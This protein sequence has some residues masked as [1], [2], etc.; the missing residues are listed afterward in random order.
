MKDYIKD[1]L[2]VL[3]VGEVKDVEVFIE[4]PI[5]SYV[6]ERRW[7]ESQQITRVERGIHFK[8]RVRV[9]DE[10]ARW[11]LGLGPSAMVVSPTELRDMVVSLASSVKNKNSQKK[12][13]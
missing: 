1:G 12:V 11:V 4:E 2:G 6:S 9:N 3:T 8:L 10:L 7:H 5:A 13:A